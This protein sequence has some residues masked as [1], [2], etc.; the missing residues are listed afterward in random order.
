MLAADQ[1]QAVVD[2]AAGLP[3]GL[4]LEIRPNAP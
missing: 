2:P 3:L 1:V 4:R